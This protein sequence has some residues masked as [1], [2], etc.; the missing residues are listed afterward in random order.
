MMVLMQTDLPEPVLPAMSTCGISTRSAMIGW[1]YTS[2][3]RAMG[4]L[5]LLLRHSSDSNMS[6][7]MTLDLTELGT[8]TPTELLPGTGARM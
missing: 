2:L 8:S 6:R 1:P 7:T 4:I 5:A 3:P